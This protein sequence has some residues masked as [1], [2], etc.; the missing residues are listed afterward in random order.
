MLRM[1]SM[2]RGH[3]ENM[4][5]LGRL[6]WEQRDLPAGMSTSPH[7]QQGAEESSSQGLRERHDLP[8]CFKC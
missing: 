7:R 1:K 5:Y 2:S 6:G 8:K 4:R 3:I